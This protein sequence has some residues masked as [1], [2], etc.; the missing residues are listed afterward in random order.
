V[1]FSIK[2]WRTHHPQPVVWGGG[3]MD[4]S[5]WNM[6]F[7]NWAPLLLLG[8]VFVMIRMRQEQQQREID[9]L[10]RFAHVS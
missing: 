5:Y 2:W 9:A 6:L 1:F 8:M 10:R 3:S 7:W 4:P